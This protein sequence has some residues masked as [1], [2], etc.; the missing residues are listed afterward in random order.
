MERPERDRGSASRTP[1]P[2]ART[3]RTTDDDVPTTMADDP[4]ESA[5][6]RFIRKLGMVATL[7]TDVRG[8]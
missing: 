4:N 3:W 7:W 5:F 1:A 2:P 6:R 8:R